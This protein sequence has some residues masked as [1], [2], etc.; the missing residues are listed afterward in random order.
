MRRLYQITDEVR[1]L[2]EKLDFLPIT[3]IWKWT[4]KQGNKKWKPS[5]ALKELTDFYF[6]E[7]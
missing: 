7:N 5:T 1:S 3:W 2:K 4:D 6:F